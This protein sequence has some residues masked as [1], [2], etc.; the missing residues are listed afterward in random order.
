MGGIMTRFQLESG[1]V[2]LMMS[3]H[4]GA[5]LT[6]TCF[7]SRTIRRAGNFFVWSSFRDFLNDTVVRTLL[8]EQFERVA[9]DWEPGRQY[10]IELSF[11][12]D[13]GWDSVMCMEDL[14]KGD[15]EGSTIQPLNSHAQALF[16]PL[17]RIEAPKTDTVTMVV[18]ARE[19]SDFKRLL[20]VHTIYPGLDCGRLVGD[21]TE[22]H[23]FVW[24]H[25]ENEGEE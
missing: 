15:L 17:N 12:S 3:R 1:E 25:W 11:S 6:T 21:M 22:K 20:F 23:G 19:T 10:R 16:L 5:R 24:L 4:H 7:R 13:I 2:M 9:S 14:R 8:A 18:Q